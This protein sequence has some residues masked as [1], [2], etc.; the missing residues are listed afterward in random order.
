VDDDIKRELAP[1]LAEDG[2]DINDP[3]TIPADRATL[4]EALNRAILRRNTALFSPAGDAREQ[5]VLALRRVVEAICAEDNL[6]ATELIDGIEPE[7][8]DNSAATVS[9]CIGLTLRLL[10]AWLPG[11]D[12]RAPA[13]LAQR[14]R[15]PR[16]PW[17]G[18]RAATDIL[19][20][21]ADGRAFQ[22]LQAMVR[23]QGGRHVLYGSTLALAAAVNAWSGVHAIP[24]PRL[25]RDVIS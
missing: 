7:S 14:T 21:A 1:F 22:S 23:E 9:A 5:A 12:E 19:D 25:A 2:I 24:V 17:I 4:R 18:A 20:L 6:L 16:G 8:A 13:T 3:A 15:L 11:D 10:D